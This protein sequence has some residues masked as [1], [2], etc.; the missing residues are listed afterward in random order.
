MIIAT[1][2]LACSFSI[3]MLVFLLGSPFVTAAPTT[4]DLRYSNTSPVNV[5]L[6]RVRRINEEGKKPPVHKDI[7]KSDELPCIVVGTL[8][9]CPQKLKTRHFKIEPLMFI[10]VDLRKSTFIILGT[11][12]IDD[13]DTLKE[14]LDDTNNQNWEKSNLIKLLTFDIT[15]DPKPGETNIDLDDRLEYMEACDKLM[16]RFRNVN[17]IGVGVSKL[18]NLPLP[19]GSSVITFTENR[20]EHNSKFTFWEEYDLAMTRSLQYEEKVKESGGEPMWR[21]DKLIESPS[22]SKG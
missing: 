8:G 12:K 6:M 10:R 19:K 7:L 1:K 13:P 18:R 20:P 22:S 3:I 17:N 21:V 5:I 9:L 11:L 14:L 4:S 15:W 16:S 2:S